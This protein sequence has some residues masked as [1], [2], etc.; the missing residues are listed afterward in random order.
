MDDVVVSSACIYTYSDDKIIV[1]YSE[2]EQNFL[3]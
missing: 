1:S 2:I 3:L